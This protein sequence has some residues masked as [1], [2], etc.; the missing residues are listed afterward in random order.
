M[1]F[2]CQ[3]CG[4]SFEDPATYRERVGEYMGTPAYEVF[5]VCPFCGDSWF[6]EEDDDDD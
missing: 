2:R 4:R 5:E 3:C 6:E 1:K